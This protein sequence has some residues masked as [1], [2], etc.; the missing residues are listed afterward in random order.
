MRLLWVFT[1]PVSNQDDA[2][3]TIEFACY[4]KTS[5]VYGFRCIRETWESLEDTIEEKQM[6]YLKIENKSTQIDED[7]VELKRTIHIFIFIFF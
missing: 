3:E 2:V 4:V 1:I 7:L 6:Q 5:A